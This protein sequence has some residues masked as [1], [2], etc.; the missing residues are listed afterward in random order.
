M[1]LEGFLFHS[2]GIP[3]LQIRPRANI[4][5][6]IVPTRK[7]I[8]TNCLARAGCVDK[9]ASAEGDSH[10]G[11]LSTTSGAKEDEIGL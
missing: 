2:R 3:A 6:S 11:D 9:S 4:A 8:N 7:G 5:I 1:L 10:V